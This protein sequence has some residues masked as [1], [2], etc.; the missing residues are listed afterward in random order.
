MLVIDGVSAGVGDIMGGRREVGGGSYDFGGVVS[1]WLVTVGSVGKGWFDG[2]S[3]DLRYW[4][5]SAMH[6][7]IVSTTVNI[8]WADGSFS[9]SIPGAVTYT[10]CAA[11]DP[12]SSIGL[13]G[14]VCDG[15]ATEG[16]GRD[17]GWVLTFGR[18]AT[19]VG[20][21]VACSGDGERLGGWDEGG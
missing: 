14:C 7:S 21:S 17:V 20:I 11:M 18:P 4:R 6:D 2:T 19:S 1:V 15:I 8:G 12:S 10:S 3:W 13:A 16:I 9:L 5:S